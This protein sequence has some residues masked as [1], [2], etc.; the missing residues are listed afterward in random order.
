MDENIRI[1]S[2]SLLMTADLNPLPALIIFVKPPVL[3]AVKTRLA[4]T[5]GD[6]RALEVYLKL[7][8]I[9]DQ[10]TKRVRAKRYLYIAAENTTLKTTT[11]LFH[12]H[13]CF[14][15][16]QLTFKLQQ[17]QTLGDRMHHALGEVLSLHKRAIL[18]GSDLPS[19]RPKHLE[20]GFES[21]GENDLVLGPSEDGGYYLIG[22]KSL[23]YNLF[24]NIDWSTEKVFRQTLD[25]AKYR[26][27]SVAFLT[28]E[29]DIDTEEDLIASGL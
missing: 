13:N 24:Q 16:H 14:A 21:L 15:D 23:D 25:R 7:L 11:A 10:V 22:L 12:G 8:Q 28:I 4:N 6:Q 5:L 29:R 9:T 17:G 1:D 18:I 19:L 26:N 20:D 3:G 27:L 2:T